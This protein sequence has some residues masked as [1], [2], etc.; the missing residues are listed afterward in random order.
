MD[1]EKAGEPNK[2]NEVTVNIQITHME[3]S[4]YLQCSR[5]SITTLLSKLRQAGYIDYDR[6]FIKIIDL[7]RIRIRIIDQYLQYELFWL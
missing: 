2:R 3:L 5:Q 4:K 7:N 1:L 6:T